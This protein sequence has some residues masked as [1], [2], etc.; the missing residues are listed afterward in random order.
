MRPALGGTLPLL[1]AGAFWLFVASGWLPQVNPWNALFQK[2]PLLNNVHLQARTL[3][4][5]F[6]FLLLAVVRRV[7]AADRRRPVAGLIIALV[8]AEALVAKSF[9]FVKQVELAKASAA[10][11][12]VASMAVV[13]TTL[14]TWPGK[15]QTP[16]FYREGGISLR[17]CYEPGIDNANL[18]IRSATDPLYRGEAYLL[19]PATGSAEIVSYTPGRLR[20]S[21]KDIKADEFSRVQVNTNDLG[22]WSVTSGVGRVV[23]SRDDL[24]TIELARNGDPGHAGVIELELRPPYVP[25]IVAAFVLGIVIACAWFLRLRSGR[26]RSSDGETHAV[27]ARS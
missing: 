12:E 18:P 7:D 5:F 13:R 6:L 9:P 2:L 26:R 25:W 16:A 3:L 10:G 15:S 27:L 17:R 4:L 23:S 22:Y 19:A 20:L 8:I 1:L 21:Y 14:E 24:L 11:F